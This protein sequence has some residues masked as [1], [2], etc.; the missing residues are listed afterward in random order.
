[1]RAFLSQTAIEIVL[2]DTN[3]GVVQ[4][5]EKRSD[6]LNTCNPVSRVDAMYMPSFNEASE[7]DIPSK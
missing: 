7:R 5:C 2:C 6:I 4:V 1:M 3:I